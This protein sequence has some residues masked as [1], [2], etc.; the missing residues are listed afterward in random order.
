MKDIPMFTTP[1]GVASLSLREIPY[2]KNAYIQ[3]RSTEMCDALIKECISFCRI[4]GAE[5]VYAQG[6]PGLDVY[7]FHTAI[8]TMRCVSEQ[9]MGKTAMLYPVLPENAVHWRRIYNERMAD[10]PLAA[11]M[12]EAEEKTLCESGEGYFVHRN[13][14]LLG[15]GRVSDDR[16]LAIASVCKG[17]GADILCTLAELLDAPTVSVEVASENKPAVSLYQRMG[18]LKTAETARWYCVYDLEKV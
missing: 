6:H 5:R 2:R 3:V 7:Q 8:W 16:I 17:Y 13:G 10:V 12:T 15:I 11:Y 14:K 1:Y 9:L 4:C 18:F